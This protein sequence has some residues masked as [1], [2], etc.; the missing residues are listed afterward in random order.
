MGNKEYE[1]GYEDALTK[2]IE[3]CRQY[4][5]DWRKLKD[6]PSKVTAACANNVID[7]LCDDI[8]AHKINRIQN[9]SRIFSV[10]M[11]PSNRAPPLEADLGSTKQWQKE[12]MGSVESFSRGFK[13]RRP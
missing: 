10:G 11:E 9:S 6:Q 12:P 4:H 5:I 13:K 2:A 7:F 1:V 8:E 3:I